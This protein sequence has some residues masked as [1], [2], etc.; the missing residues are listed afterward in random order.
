M[1]IYDPT[2]IDDGAF[3]SKIVNGYRLG[4]FMDF[5]GPFF[6][7]IVHLLTSSFERQKKS[8]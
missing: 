6:M 5:S 2:D 8:I 3:S 1:R 4:Y 7:E